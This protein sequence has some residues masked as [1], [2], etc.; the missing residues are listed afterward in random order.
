MKHFFCILFSF[1]FTS[2]QVWIQLPDFPGIKR[3]D[4]VAVVVGN[5]AYVGTG[6]VE[7]ALTLDFWVLDLNSY[8]WSYGVAMPP[9]TNRQYACTFAGNNSFYVFGGDGNNGACA[10]MYRFDVS[11]NTW[12]AVASKP[13]NGLIGASC[14]NFGDKV[15]ICGGKFQSGKASAEVWEY[16]IST[17]SWQQKNNYPFAG[18][19][20]AS[21]T[22]LNGFGY[23]VFG[24]D[25]GGAFCKEL[26]KYA[27]ASDSWTKISE[28]PVNKG[29]AYAA[30]QTVNNRLFLFA[31][32]D[33]LDQVYKNCWYYT[34][35]SNTWDPGP[36]L[37]STGRKG[38][39]SYAAGDKFFYTCGI[40][41]GPAR[42]TET[43]MTDVPLGVKEQHKQSII[44]IYPNPVKD[45]IWLQITGK[46]ERLR[47]SYTDLSGRVL[48]TIELENGEGW[49]DLR[50]LSS[51]I[52][53]LKVFSSEG[54][55]ES[56]KIIKE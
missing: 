21:A 12:T 54:L 40:T 1:Q 7:W 26:Y 14:M 3:D 17:N 6:L 34:E 28:A 52:Y 18:R 27:P 33:S 15:I 45:L 50:D 2:A 42:T 41:E 47:C 24:R 51:G 55:L 32:I 4:G 25:S 43:W 56:R 39:M 5:K 29:R 22:V 16:T 8:T 49:I 53:F 48:G 13:G 44:S 19:W 11:T 46:N 31:G 37:P 38:G 9:S 20:R 23:L 35:A 36:D 30:F 10:D